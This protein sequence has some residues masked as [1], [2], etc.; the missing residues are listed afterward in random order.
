MQLTKHSFPFS[1]CTL[2]VYSEAK[3]FSPSPTTVLSNLSN[4]RP[5]S[6]TLTVIG[7]LQETSKSSQEIPRAAWSFLLSSLGQT[8]LNNHVARLSITA[9]QEGTRKMRDETLSSVGAQEMDT[10]GY[11][12]SDLDDMEFHWEDPD[13]IMAA[14]FRPGKD[15]IL[16]PSTSIKFE[17]GSMAQNPNLI[18]GEQDK[19]NSPLPPL[20]TAPLSGNQPSP[21]CR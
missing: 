3:S 12:V 19:E 6:V 1:L 2:P 14:I 16:S 9:N 8:F 18:D 10:S 17:T 5:D 21:F 11:E 20:P 4:F 15:T 13:L 7:L